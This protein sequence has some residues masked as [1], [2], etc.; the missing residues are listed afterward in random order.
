MSEER[1]IGVGVERE[2]RK[3]LK[4]E[5]STNPKALSLAQQ[6]LEVYAREG[7]KGVVRLVRNLVEGE[8]GAGSAEE[9]GG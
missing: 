7:R 8:T 1:F 6:I 5:L 2:V 4:Q 3:L 9:L